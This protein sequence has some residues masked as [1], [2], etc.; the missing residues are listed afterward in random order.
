MT[1]PTSLEVERL[2]SD[3]LKL[4]DADKTGMF[5][6]ALETSGGAVVSTRCTQTYTEREPTLSWLSLNL[7]GWIAHPLRYI[8]KHFQTSRDFNQKTFLLMIC[9][10]F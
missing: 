9:L 6:F 3:A 8:Q 1:D 4:Y 2:V 7:P 5:D 10:P